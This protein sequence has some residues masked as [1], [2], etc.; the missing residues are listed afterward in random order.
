MSTNAPQAS[1]S[2]GHL[3]LWTLSY[4]Q[5]AAGVAG[6]LVK[7]E[8]RDRYLGCLLGGAVGDALGAPLEFM[9][10]AEI[11]ATVA[12]TQR[13]SIGP[14]GVRDYGAAY[15]RTGAITDDTQMTLFTAE[16]LLRAHNRL[17]ANGIGEPPALVHRAY[18]RWLETQLNSQPPPRPNGWLASVEGLYRR[19]SPGQTCMSALRTGVR[20]SRERPIN[21][22]KGCGGVM[23]VAP[24][25]LTKWDAFELGC[26]VAAITHTHPLGYVSAGA[27]AVMIRAIIDG[28]RLTQA[29]DA[30]AR[31]VRGVEG[32]TGLK[33]L[34]ERAMYIAELGDPSPEHLVSLGEG[35]VAEEAL[36]MGL[37]CAASVD[38]FEDGVALAVLHGGDSDSTGAIAGNLLGAMYGV[39][40]IPDGLLRGLELYEEIVRLANDLYLHF[41]VADFETSEDD[42]LRY[43]G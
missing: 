39:A 27:F 28:K 29:A 8:A 10:M 43:P 4:N 30:A 15:G 5:T 13:D 40:G 9:S 7:V 21:N 36:A 25:G 17:L 19:R 31:A 26:D 42:W 12:I 22:S 35:W 33:E 41:Q 6:V 14:P 20:G 34:L 2:G 38:N 11:Q 18:L 23:R 16:G 24:V 3:R 1:R 32:A 37:Y